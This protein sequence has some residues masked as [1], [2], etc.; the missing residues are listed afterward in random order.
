MKIGF[1][2]LGNLGAPIARRLMSRG[3]EL[4]VLD[5]RSDAMS[6]FVAQGALA[7]RTPRE[8]A[9]VAQVV[10]VCLPSTDAVEEV[11][12]GESGVAGGAAVRIFIDL[13]TSDPE[14]AQ[15]IAQ[16]LAESSIAMLDSPVSGGV[17]RAQAGT[18]TVMVSGAA[19]TLS[20]VRALL[21][22]IGPVHHLGERPGSAQVMK[23]INNLLSAAAFTATAEAM[24]MGVKAGLDASQMI[25]VLNTGTGRN[26]ATQDKFPHAILSRTFHIGAAT[27]VMIKDVSLCMEHAAR[28]GL[29]LSLA[30]PMLDLWGQVAQEQGADSDYSEIV[31][32]LERRAGV[33]VKA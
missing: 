7:A 15:A 27:S 25:E 3:H 20:E 12:C 18:L 26:S 30:Q 24:V 31:K 32:M 9:D 1:I 23:L 29:K 5:S 28:L 13:S 14:R 21:D 16:R 11:A 6:P 33:E 4:V 17:L 2:G 19:Q 10:F 22:A 8:V